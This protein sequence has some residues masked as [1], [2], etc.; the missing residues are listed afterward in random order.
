MSEC[1]IVASADENMVDLS[2]QGPDTTE[3]NRLFDEALQSRASSVVTE[4]IE[5]YNV[6]DGRQHTTLRRRSPLALQ[7]AVPHPPR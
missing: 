4:S 5:E 6:D 1:G 2:L 3:F 7:S